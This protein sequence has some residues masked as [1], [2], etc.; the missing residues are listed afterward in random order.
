MP[1]NWFRKRES[2]KILDNTFGEL[3]LENGFWSREIDFE[4]ANTRIH[5]YLRDAGGR[6]VDSASATFN[7]FSRRYSALQSAFA[8]E[9][10]TLFEPWYEE[11]GEE[12]QALEQ[13]EKLMSRFELFAIE[14]D[15]SGVARVEFG[16]KEGWDDAVFSVALQGW[17]PKAM[18]VED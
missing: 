11:F 17:V 6:P 15:A 4:P 13:G 16:L 8:P 14:I 10:R 3:W 1:F 7:E 5:L 18:G 9:L 12:K 2:P